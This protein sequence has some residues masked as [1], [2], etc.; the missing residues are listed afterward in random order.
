MSEFDR[1]GLVTFNHLAWRN[2]RLTTCTENNLISLLDSIEDVEA[3]GGTDLE[4][5]IQCGLS[6]LKER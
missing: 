2:I 3:Y 6:M 1:F 5:G 4:A